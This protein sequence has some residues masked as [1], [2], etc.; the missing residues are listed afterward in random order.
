[1]S[2]MLSD[3]MGGDNDDDNSELSEHA[4]FLCKGKHT[5]DLKTVPNAMD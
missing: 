1:M 2:I 4:R 3:M 5:L